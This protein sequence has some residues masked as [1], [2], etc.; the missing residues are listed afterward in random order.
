MYLLGLFVKSFLFAPTLI[1][2]ASSITDNSSRSE[3]MAC[4]ISGFS[5]ASV[6][7]RSSAPYFNFTS[8]GRPGWMSW[9]HNNTMVFSMEG[10]RSS[11]SMTTS[12]WCVMP[13]PSTSRLSLKKAVRCWKR[14][15]GFSSGCRVIYAKLRK[16]DPAD[17]NRKCSLIFCQMS[18]S[19]V[20]CFILEF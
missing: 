17:W 19:E 11:S 12:P 15:S 20:G 3:V 13:H 14:S 8:W 6:L 18:L 7:F 10:V 4:E 2:L 16:L 9:S 1:D 5:D